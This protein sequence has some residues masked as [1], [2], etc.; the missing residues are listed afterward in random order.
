YQ[1]RCTLLAKEKRNGLEADKSAMKRLVNLIQLVLDPVL[2][3]YFRDHGMNSLKFMNSN[4]ILKDTIAEDLEATA[5]DEYMM[6]FTYTNRLN[7]QRNMDNTRRLFMMVFHYDILKC[8]IP[9]ASGRRL[10][11]N[12]RSKVEEFLKPILLTSQVAS[13]VK[14]DELDTWIR[15]GMKLAAL[16]NKFGPGCLF[17]LADHLSEN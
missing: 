10:N 14:F 12:L 1:E 13:T 2:L 9:S 15:C 16:C 8:A 4:D 11:P 7:G 17:Y 6:R 5:G 3:E